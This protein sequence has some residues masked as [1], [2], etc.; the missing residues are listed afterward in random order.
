[1]KADA[2]SP[3]LT[4]VTGAGDKA[5][6]LSSFNIAAIMVAHCAGMLDL[7]ALP[8]WIGSLTSTYRF[9]AQQAGGVVT[10]FLLGVVLSSCYFAPRLNRIR[11]RLA[12]PTGYAVAALAL[13][14]CAFVTQYQILIGLHLA[15]GVAVGC[16]LSLTH[17][18]L[19]LSRNPHRLFAMAGLALGVFAIAFVVVTPISMAQYGGVA[20]FKVFA[21]VM[22]VAAVV[23]AVAFPSSE[24]NGT[25]AAKSDA[26]LSKAVW[27]GMFG[28][29][30][31]ALNQSMI[32]SFVMRIGLDRGFGVAAVTSVLVALGFVNL[33]PAPLAAVLQRK[34]SARAVLV[35][36]PL[37][38][39]ALAISISYSSAFAP[40]AM[41][42]G[43]FSAVVIFTHTF[44]FGTLATIDKSGRA[45]AATP[46]MLMTGAAVGPILA[47][48]LVKSFG[49][50]SLGAIAT[51]IAIVASTCFSR[52]ARAR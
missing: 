23:T 10:C 12:V 48:T 1:M 19:G 41:A 36:G 46:V 45:V 20:L 32:F 42:A 16:S 4:T 11:Q 47:G 28:V 17:G 9:D 15:A 6:N 27:L 37:V 22:L 31:I 49:Y 18:V 33:L 24:M 39:A 35:T 34:L 13:G 40:Y 21:V 7:V 29:S 26:K 30:C 3:A 8:L 52:T 5:T 38:Q 50:G 43:V 51:V 14:A 44:A 25:V 2:I